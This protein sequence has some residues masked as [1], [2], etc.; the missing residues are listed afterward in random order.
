[1][2]TRNPL[3]LVTGASAGI[4]EA[5]AAE[6]AAAGH[7]LVLVARRTARLRALAR[8]LQQEHDVVAHVRTADLL[9]TGAVARL[10]RRLSREGLAV[11]VLVNNAGLL[12]AG[13]FLAMEPAVLDRMLQLNVGVLTAML[14]HFLPAMRERGSGRIMNVA[15]IAAFQPLVGL[16]SYAATKAYVLSLGEALTEELRG[17][18][19][20]V[21]TLC[22]GVTDT[23]MIAHAADEAPAF[24]ELPRVLIGEPTAVARAGV[25]GLLSGETI[26]VPGAL[27][28]ATTL[29]SDNLPRRLRR[30]LVG[31]LGRRRLQR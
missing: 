8:D 1:M 7:D 12:E 22:P 27:N 20:T 5:I 21:T 4:G 24:G 11:D 26:V 13:P 10:E 18:G 14:A 28:R 19:I 25:R 9:E 29:F 15:S 17:S 30:R 31:A 2:S 23:A 16:A 3:A 6:L